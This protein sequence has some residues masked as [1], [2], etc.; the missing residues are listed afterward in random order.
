MT[1]SFASISFSR[2]SPSRSVVWIQNTRARF[3][4]VMMS[5]AQYLRPSEYR[6]YAVELRKL[7]PIPT[8]KPVTVRRMELIPTAKQ[9]H[10]QY[11][12]E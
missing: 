8:T 3:W 2:N 11:M 1:Y 5:W 12:P 4:E 9:M 6:S 7:K 10:D